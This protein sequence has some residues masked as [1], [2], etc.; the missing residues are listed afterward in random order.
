MFIVVQLMLQLGRKHFCTKNLLV[1]Y[2]K[3]EKEKP[4]NVQVTR[5]STVI[6]LGIFI[7]QKSVMIFNGEV[8][9][10]TQRKSFVRSEGGR[11]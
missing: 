9:I 8:I 3:K 1:N 4:Y 6:Q 11:Y 2:N 7:L 10:Q 5:S